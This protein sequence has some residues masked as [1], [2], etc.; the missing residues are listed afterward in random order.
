MRI[1][2]EEAEKLI[3]M[4][5]KYLG[6]KEFVF[7]NSKGKICFEVKGERRTDDF[8]VNIERK[9]IDASKMTYQGRVK[10]NNTILMRIDINPT[11]IHTNP[12]GETIYGS[13]IHIYSKDF[14]IKEAIPINWNDKDPFEACFDFFEKFNII[15]YPKIKPDPNQE[16]G[17]I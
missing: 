4:I 7:P 11:S 12:S 13:H 1:T 15:E 6:N 17:L 10:S 3:A 14:D 8:V 9:G 2:K 16:L 5:K